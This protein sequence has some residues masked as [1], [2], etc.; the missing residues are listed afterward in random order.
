MTTKPSRPTSPETN[1]QTRE[2]RAGRVPRARLAAANA[3]IMRAAA[4]SFIRAVGPDP[5]TGWDHGR[6]HVSALLCFD[7]LQVGAWVLSYNSLMPVSIL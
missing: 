6:G 4:R 1:I 7:E 5:A 3:A 2:T